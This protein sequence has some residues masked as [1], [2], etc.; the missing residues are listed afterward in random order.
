MEEAELL[1]DWQQQVTEEEELLE[2][3]QREVTEQEDPLEDCQQG[4]TEQEDQL[5]DQKW[6]VMEEKEPLEDWQQEVEEDDFEEEREVEELERE[7]EAG[8]AGAREYNERRTEEKKWRV[9]RREM[10][11]MALPFLT[12]ISP[13]GFLIA[14]RK[15]PGGTDDQVQVSS[16]C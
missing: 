7:D 15:Q 1:E 12:G 14:N 13:A 10:M 8:S 6:E 5:D 11:G 2:D 4:V 16:P 3:Y 9:E